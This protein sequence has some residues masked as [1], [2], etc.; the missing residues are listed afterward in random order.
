MKRLYYLW[1]VLILIVGVAGTVAVA[2]STA[3]SE[4]CN[5]FTVN[6]RY[7]ELSGFTDGLMPGNTYE[8]TMS[9]TND[10]DERW[11]S[12]YCI[13]LVDGETVVLNIDSNSID[14]PPTVKITSTVSMTLPADF[15][16]G[17]Y[18]LALV[19]PD[20]GSSITTIRIGNVTSPPAGPWP[21]FPTCP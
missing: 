1:A 9:L 18:G 5:P 2:C 4:P 13:F 7:A 8:F 12:S 14:L 3:P 21:D 6:W 19:I 10:T 16:E 11:Q 17:A 20:R 15:P